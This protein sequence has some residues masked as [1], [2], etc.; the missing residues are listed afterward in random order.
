MDW[1]AFRSQGV[2]ALIA[3]VVLLGLLSVEFRGLAGEEAPERA[4]T[5][6]GKELAGK[7]L[8]GQDRRG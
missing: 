5:L 6:F 8:V 7:P 2:F 3:S 4:E 1:K